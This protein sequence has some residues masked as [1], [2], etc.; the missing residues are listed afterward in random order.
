MFR[1]SARPA[2]PSRLAH[3]IETVMTAVARAVFRNP[4][5]AALAL[6][7]LVGIGL[8]GARQIAR[9]GSIE[10]FFHPDAPEIAA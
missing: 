6:V 8:A 7:A 10:G 1:K 4:L 5:L 9:D 2:D 3:G